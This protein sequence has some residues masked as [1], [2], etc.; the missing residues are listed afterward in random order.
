MRRLITTNRHYTLVKS[1][2][3]QPVRYLVSFESDKEEEE[4]D[5]DLVEPCNSTVAAAPSPIEEDV[6]YI[7]VQTY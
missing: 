1:K 3:L 4:D 5:E 7:H 2:D 6:D